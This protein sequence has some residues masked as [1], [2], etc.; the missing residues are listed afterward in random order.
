MCILGRQ[1]ALGLAELESLYGAKHLKPCLPAG[2]QSAGFALL[3]VP[4]GEINFKR[5]GGT[6]KVAKILTVL[7]Y[8]DWHRL[9]DYLKHNIPKHLKYLPEGRFRLGV[10]IYAIEVPIRT[11]N[12]NLLEIK[13]IIR[14]SGRPVRIIPNKT[15]E[16]NTAQVLHNKLTHRGGWELLL[17]KNANQTILAQTM[18]VQ[19]IEAYAARDQARPARDARVG[20]LPPKLAQIILNLALGRAENEEW[21]MKNEGKS[22][23]VWAILDPFCGTGV[24]LQEAMLMGYDAVGT[25]IDERMVE[26]AKKNIQWLVQKYPGLSSNVSIEVA[27]A[28]NYKWPHFTAVASEVYLGR[29]LTSLPLEVEFKKIM[30]DV[31]TIIKKFLANI[32]PQLQPGRRLC[33]AIPAWRTGKELKHLPLI[34]NLKELGYN[35][36]DFVHAKNDE[37]VYFR[38][39]Q[40]VAREL[41]ILEARG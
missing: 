36:F 21:R 37:L 19:D 2:R 13:N 11:L 15:A 27:D 6:L 25:D 9:F 26:Y 20:M 1:P 10:S 31:N 4:A 18:F 34:D 41:L 29:P 5:L 28:T 24:I 22:R 38:E 8:T 40:I 14:Q 17:I 39:D 3:D 12:A 32:G 7:P 23:A 16:L 30:S 33:I 35:R